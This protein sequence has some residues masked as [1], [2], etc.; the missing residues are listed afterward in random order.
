M[1]PKLTILQAFNAMT[2]FLDDYYHKTLS[3]DVGS[4][5]GD[6]LFLQDGYTADAATWEDWTDVIE[7]D[8]PVTKL[9]AFDAMRKFIDN[10][11]KRTS[12][13]SLD[14]RELLHDMK[15]I[16]N[17]KTMN[18]N[19]WKIWIECVD[20]TLREPEGSRSFLELKK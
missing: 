20:E 9:Q 15:L 10:Y 16:E 2:K 18:P 3:D 6:M 17:N 8:Q 5:L 14:I 12:S 4:L 11:Y 13:T 1:E 19:T 7:T